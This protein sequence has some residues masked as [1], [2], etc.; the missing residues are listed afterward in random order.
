MGN[1]RWTGVSLKAVR[2][3]AGVA[4]VAVDGL[5]GPVVPE[6]PDFVEALTID[7]ARSGEV[8]LAWGMNGQDLPFLNG[9]PVRLLVPG[10]SGAYWAKHLGA[11]T[12]LDQPFEGSWMKSAYRIPDTPC[13]CSA[14]GK[15]PAAGVPIA[16]PNVRSFVTNLS[17]GAKIEAGPTALRGIAF[18]GG[19]GIERVALS[20]DDGRTWMPAELGQDLGRYAFRTWTATAELGAGLHAIRVRATAK[21]GASRPMEPRWNPPGYLRNVVETT[22]VRAA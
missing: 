17:D 22:R 9:F 13:A 12:V 11:I 18:E 5:D 8:M 10:F 3:A 1:A 4:Q 21:D 14:P 7:H 20:T 6:T 16:R 15:A 2:D 19:S